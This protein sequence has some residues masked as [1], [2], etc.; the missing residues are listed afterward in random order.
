MYFKIVY[1]NNDKSNSYIYHI[2]ATS[3][4]NT[5]LA[6]TMFCTYQFYSAFG[7]ILDIVGVLILFKYGLPSKVKE[8][9]GGLLLEENSEEEK[10]RISDNN[11]ITRRAYLGLTL[12]LIG[13]F[14]QLIGTLLSVDK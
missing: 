8:H 12:L 3:F 6:L 4:V 14:L 7:L 9:G 10:L 2:Y 11:K 5:M 13:F 1:Q